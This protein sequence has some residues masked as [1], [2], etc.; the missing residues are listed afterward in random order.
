MMDA[1][2]WTYRSRHRCRALATVYCCLSVASLSTPPVGLA[3]WRR[4]G[5][6]TPLHGPVALGRLSRV[7]A[8]CPILPAASFL[9]PTPCGPGGVGSLGV[10]DCAA[11]AVA[12]RRMRAG[13]MYWLPVLNVVMRRHV[14]RAGC[15]CLSAP[16]SLHAWR[17]GAWARGGGRRVGRIYTGPGCRHTL[18]LQLGILIPAAGYRYHGRGI[19]LRVY[20]LCRLPAVLQGGGRRC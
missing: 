12:L 7:R 19:N 14:V 15:L 20:S 1:V 9:P 10:L 18:G 5:C 13:W 3:G 16:L 11:G 8:D 2:A 6:W 17:R 4:L